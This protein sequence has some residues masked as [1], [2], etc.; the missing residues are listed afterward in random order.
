MF[1]LTILAATGLIYGLVKLG[2]PL[3]PRSLKAPKPPPMPDPITH[4]KTRPRL[5]P[6]RRDLRPYRA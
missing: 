6:H 2:N 1:L 5:A 3:A 4:H